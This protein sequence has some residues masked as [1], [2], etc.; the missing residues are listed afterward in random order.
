[1]ALP[2][3]DLTGKVALVTGGTRGIGRRLVQCLAEAGADVAVVSRHLD[4]AEEVAREVAGMG[5][6]S[7][8]LAHD[9][10]RA[11]E[12]MA[13]VE[14]AVNALGRLDILV[15]NAGM[16]QVK[17]ALEVTE[18]DW[19]MVLNLNLKGLFF[20]CQAAARIMI[21]QGGGKIINIASVGGVI[22]ESKMAPYAAS[23]AGVISLTKSL[24]REWG[25]YNIQVNAIGPGYVRTEMNRE[26][27]QDEKV[28][29]S[30]LST[31]P[32]RRIGEVE[33]LDGALLFLASSASD[34]VTGHTLF[35]DGGRLT[36]TKS[37]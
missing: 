24:A 10:S 27:F 2:S 29:Q 22:G 26:A 12:A 16:T 33:D 18:A 17:P 3:F 1:M 32:L 20:A 19:D 34:F 25:R 23:K 30:I 36:G 13:M 31:I 28:Y 15:N 7:L 35:V 37:V 5:R 11:A 9:V 6:R 14:E 21:P 8:A 4:Q